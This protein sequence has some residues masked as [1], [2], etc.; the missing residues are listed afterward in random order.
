MENKD[1]YLNDYSDDYSDYKDPIENT[2]GNYVSMTIEELPYDQKSDDVYLRTDSLPS[3]SSPS[4]SSP[5]LSPPSLSPIFPKTKMNIYKK[6]KTG[7]RKTKLKKTNKNPKKKTLK[8][9]FY[10]KKNPK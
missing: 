1:D 5:S 4:L 6:K 7:V 3:L 8:K 10:L 9:L 2:D